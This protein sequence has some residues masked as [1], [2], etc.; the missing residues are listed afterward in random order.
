[1]NC[2]KSDIDLEHPCWNGYRELLERLPGESFPGTETLS[3]ELTQGICS[4]H[5]APIRFQPAAS[6]P[7]VDYELHIFETGEVSTREQNWHDLF[8]A[9]VWCRLP[10]LK[11][12]MNALHYEHLDLSHGGQRGRLRDAL[13]LL[14]ESG[15]IVA[16]S[17]IDLLNA[18]AN[19]DWHAAFVTHRASWAEET[20]VMVCGHAI[21][22]K[23]LQ[24][25]KSITAH[26]LLLHTPSVM[27]RGD[28]D[29]LLGSS[30]SNPRWLQSP[31]MLSPLPLMGIPGWWGAGEQN[32]DFYD[33]QDVFRP[34]SGRRS[35]APVFVPGET[36]PMTDP[37]HLQIQS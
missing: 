30:L 21:L 4:R 1:M 13:T 24:P 7:G 22:E 28:I 27:S 11:V 2:W 32:R 35:P 33:D 26:A 10:R 8:N 36:W 9:L 31:A 19:R 3:A 23:F 37:G 17:N 6:L 12:A 16:G 5:G 14:D 15:I 20:R 25:Y 29:R 34:L 18:L